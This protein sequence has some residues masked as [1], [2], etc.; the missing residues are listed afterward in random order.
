MGIGMASAKVTIDA[1]DVDDLEDIEE[2][3]ESEETV[4]HKPEDMAQ[5]HEQQDE[6][7]PPDWIES[8]GIRYVTLKQGDC[9]KKAEFG[10]VVHITHIGAK[11]GLDE[12][13]QQRMEQFDGSGDKPLKVT[14]G[15][16]RIIKGMERGMLGQCQ[17]EQRN[18]LIPPQLAFDDPT[19]RFNQKP[20][21]D[22]TMILY[23][24]T[25]NRITKTGSSSGFMNDIVDDFWGTLGKYY[26]VIIFFAIVA[27]LVYKC[28]PK[29]RP[30]SKKKKKTG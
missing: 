19:V 27:G 24:I 21:P 30:I 7:P 16:N 11:P 1:S 10:D 17:G 15:E 8:N 5:Q 28:G 6:G 13:G 9:R 22:G 2:D 26:Q 18:I 12:Q 4:I 23:Q 3:D 25:I 14:L 29:R 20:V